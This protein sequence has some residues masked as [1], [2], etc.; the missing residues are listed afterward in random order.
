VVVVV[1]VDK[2]T[3]PPLSADRPKPVNRVKSHEATAASGQAEPS[4]TTTR[5]RRFW[6]SSRG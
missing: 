3:V 1:L 5:S 2:A 4:S 6:G